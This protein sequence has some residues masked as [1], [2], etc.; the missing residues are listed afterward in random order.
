M[1]LIVLPL[2]LLRHV[3]KPVSVE[4]FWSDQGFLPGGVATLVGGSGLW[5]SP[6]EERAQETA[7]SAAIE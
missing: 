5:R 7:P 2:L 6:R 3:N 4:W 1:V